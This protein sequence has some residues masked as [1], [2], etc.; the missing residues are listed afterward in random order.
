[1]PQL[2]DLGEATLADVERHK[3]LM[4]AESF[5]RC[6][7]IVTENAR[8]RATEAALQ[9]GD[10]RKTGLLLLEAHASQR[11]DFQCS[12]QEIDFL[13][14]TAA[15]LQGCFGA[16]MTGGGFGGCTVNLVENGQV[17]SFIAS[18]TSAYRT[19]FDVEAETYVCTAVA[20]AWQ[21]N[22]AMLPPASISTTG[23]TA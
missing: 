20:G 14:D 4:S 10:V 11:D 22:A 8:V 2:R 13:V 16:R 21:R 15:G 6:R 18:L 19:R 7:H 3:D 1:M 23:A 17:E 9:E 12:V 5:R